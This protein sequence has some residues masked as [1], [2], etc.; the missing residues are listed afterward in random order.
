MSKLHELFGIRERRY[1]LDGSRWPQ[2]M[3]IELELEQVKN[4][5]E[6]AYWT[7][8]QDNSLRDGV[9]LVLD[10]PYAGMTLEAALDEYFGAGLHCN[11]TARTSTHIHI[12]MTDATLDCLRTMTMIMYMIEDPLFTAVGEARKWAGYAMPLSDMEPQR[13]RQLLAASDLGVAVNQ[14]APGRNQERYYGFNTA[15]MRKHG[16]VEFR[17]YPG[18]PT[19][20]ELQNWMDLAV[21][22]KKAGSEITPTQLIDR[23]VDPESVIEFLSEYF[24]DYW[25]NTLLRH[26]DANYMLTKFNEV[27]ALAFEQEVLERREQLV[28][29]TVPFISFVKRHLLGEAG[30]VYIDGIKTTFE[31]LS[32]GDWWYHFRHAEDLDGAVR[33]DRPKPKKKGPFAYYGDAATDPFADVIR[34]ANAQM[35]GREAIADGW[36]AAPVWEDV[37]PP[38]ARPAPPPVDDDADNDDYIDEDHDDDE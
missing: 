36:A 20:E 25:M 16:T 30:R 35:P 18:G 5:R 33:E 7:Q 12:N 13:L 32:A 34:R 1:K 31:V 38:Q 10:Q 15:S 6:I 17:Y 3:G 27:A 2:L 21:Q 26:V 4:L 19:R 11:N 9:E 28:F 14:I 24:P 29:M 37:P 23:L 8:H 22:V